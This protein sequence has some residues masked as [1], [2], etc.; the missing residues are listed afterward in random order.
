MG[1]PRVVVDV[2]RDYL[3]ACD[4]NAPGLVEGLY[5]IGSVALDD[6]CEASSDIDFVA[7]SQ[8]RPDPSTVDTLDRVHAAV[9]LAHPRPHFDGV[10]VT[11][12][13][14]AADPRWSPPGPQ[15][16]A[17][18]LYPTS[19]GE[20]HP[21][22]WHTLAYHGVA[23]RGPAPHKLAVWTDPSTVA[24][25]ARDD[26]HGYWRAWHRQRSRLLA[27]SGLAGPVT[28]AIAEGVLVVSRL[29]HTAAT[30]AIISK[31]D[32]AGYATDTFGPRWAPIVREALRIRAGEPR[33]RGPHLKPAP[34]NSLR[35][36]AQALAYVAMVL[37]DVRRPPRQ[38]DGR[39]DQDPAPPP[40]PA[41]TT[42]DPTVP[43]DGVSRTEAR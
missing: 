25:C 27:A 3:Q 8:R 10:Y 29:H 11:W 13:E 26:L 42:P 9:R 19:R 28:P 21:V 32:A 6:F 35:H 24:S 36:R 43:A 22:T 38:R 12:S 4:S 31:R 34:H 1:V 40:V 30:G 41:G 17:G 15:S 16:Y 39:H 14:L 23:I 7:V 20:R 37:D 33:R 5:L 18:H 2:A